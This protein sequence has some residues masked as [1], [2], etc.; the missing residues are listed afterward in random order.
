[1]SET[2]SSAEIETL[3][4]HVIVW[5]TRKDQHEIISIKFS[6]VNLKVIPKIGQISQNLLRKLYTRRVSPGPLLLVWC[7]NSI[8]FSLLAYLG[9]LDRRYIFLE[10]EDLKCESQAISVIKPSD[11]LH[12]IKTVEIDRW[13][14]IHPHQIRLLD[15]E[16][17]SRYRGCSLAS[18]CKNVNW[19]QEFKGNYSLEVRNE[20]DPV[21]LS[22]LLA[23]FFFR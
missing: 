1:M 9:I 18:I 19:P 5:I 14:V 3:F 7:L 11:L 15:T 23:Y 21:P 8:T 12:L 2:Y 22:T 10:R 20:G 17:E 4:C 16:R 6:N 13:S